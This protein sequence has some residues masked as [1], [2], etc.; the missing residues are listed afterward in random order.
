[1]PRADDGGNVPAASSLQDIRL[2]TLIIS[3]ALLVSVGD[4]VITSPTLST[5]WASPR[6]G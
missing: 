1:M 2:M 3:T 4:G 5:E 6:R